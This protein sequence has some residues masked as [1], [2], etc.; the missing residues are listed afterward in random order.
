VDA[1]DA[2]SHRAGSI[3]VLNGASSAGKSTLA[4]ALQA[5]L[6]LPFWHWSIDHLRAAKVLPWSRI[7]GGEFPWPGL[8]ES[9]F[10]GF[11]RSI[12]AFAA[13]GNP[14]IVEHIVEREAWLRRLVGLLAGHDV[15][16]VGVHCPLE[17]LERRERLRGDRRLG[18]ARADFAVTHGFGPYDHECAVTGDVG[19]V[20]D[21]VVRAW[22][23]RRAPGAFERMHRAWGAAE[24]G[25]R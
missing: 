8:R 14:L 9:F 18:E 13:A 16:F 12:A 19:A 4:A 17:E 21:A 1:A 3:I 22:A 23:G 2:A 6:P 25:P 20:A 15:F 5:R 11:H 7:D 10:D 24:G